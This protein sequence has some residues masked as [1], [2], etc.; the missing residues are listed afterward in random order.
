M[1]IQDWGSEEYERQIRNAIP[2]GFWGLDAKAEKDIAHGTALERERIAVYV[3]SGPVVRKSVRIA[4]NIELYNERPMTPT[5]LAQAIRNGEH[6][7][8]EGDD[9]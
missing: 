2:P 4:S 9:E 8:T 1:T 7:R 6:N 5:E 3:A